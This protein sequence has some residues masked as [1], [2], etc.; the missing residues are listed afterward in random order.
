LRAT[1]KIATLFA[2][3]SLKTSLLRSIKSYNGPLGRQFDWIWGNLPWPDGDT[4]IGLDAH[5]TITLL[6]IVKAQL[7][8]GDFHLT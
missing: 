5:D 8:A 7:S 4:V 6:G 3:L 2:M 1:E